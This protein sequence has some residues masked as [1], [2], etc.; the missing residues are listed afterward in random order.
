M[1]PNL[2]F[3]SD[4]KGSN[5]I[6]KLCKVKSGA[7]RR[8]ILMESIHHGLAN[9]LTELELHVQRVSEHFKDQARKSKS[10]AVQCRPFILR[11]I[12]M[13]S[14]PVVT[15]LDRGQCHMQSLVLIN[16]YED[17]NLKG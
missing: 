8:V 11:P 12:E 9:F 16:A 13:M 3:D 15:S 7:D 2:F 4:E 14:S 10:A 1:L 17:C 6:S 5:C